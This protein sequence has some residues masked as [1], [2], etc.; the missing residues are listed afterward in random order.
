MIGGHNPMTTHTPASSNAER[1]TT[2]YWAFRRA[3]GNALGYEPSPYYDWAWLDGDTVREYPA[4]DTDMND[5]IQLL[6]TVS[7]EYTP[8]LVRLLQPTGNQGIVYV[9]KCVIMSNLADGNDEY[10]AFADTPAL[11]ICFA[12]LAANPQPADGDE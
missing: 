6:E 11:A 8:R 3:I 12:W 5:A 10:T 1:T 2:V 4:W 7:D 9:W